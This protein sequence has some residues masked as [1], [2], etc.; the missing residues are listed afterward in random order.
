MDSN[1][2][3]RFKPYK[4]KI[5]SES[6]SQRKL[7]L[8]SISCKIGTLKSFLSVEDFRKNV[9]ALPE[10]FKFNVDSGSRKKVHK[11][12]LSMNDEPSNNLKK[13][14]SSILNGIQEDQAESVDER[15]R[16]LYDKYTINRQK[17]AINI[18]KMIVEEVKQQGG[19]SPR[20]DDSEDTINT[21]EYSD[22]DILLD[23]RKL[24]KK[25]QKYSKLEEKLDKIS[26]ISQNLFKIASPNEKI[27]K[28]KNFKNELLRAELVPGEFE[29]TNSHESN[30]HRISRAKEK[31]V[32]EDSIIQSGDFS[33]LFAETPYI[34]NVYKTTY[35]L[36][37][38]L[39][40][41]LPTIEDPKQSSKILQQKIELS[42][43]F[44]QKTSKLKRSFVTINR[45]C[46][47]L[48]LMKI[49]NMLG[50][51]IIQYFTSYKSL[52]R[53]DLSGNCIGDK[54]VAFLVYCLNKFSPGLEYLDLS[55]TQ[56]SAYTSRAVQAILESSQIQ[57]LKL[58]KNLFG[59]EGVLC[60]SVGLLATNS[61][62]FINLADNQTEIAAGLA[63]AKVFRLNR[64]LKG[65]NISKNLISGKAIKEISR[66]LIVNTSLRSLVMNGCLLDDEDAKEIGHM[67]NA[68]KKL[69]QLGLSYNKITYKGLEYLKYGL[70]KNKSLIHLSLTGNKDI[71]LPALEKIKH[72]MPKYFEIEIGKED[73][74]FKTDEA[75]KLK[76]IDYFR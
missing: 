7:V 17:A 67:L 28:K 68:N 71:K 49:D 44:Q 5:N 38:Q 66:S 46:I 36:V 73:E 64:S 39:I 34:S 12:Y 47:S 61:L 70:P 52:T 1:F 60:I 8:P 57:H 45:S 40:P 19:Y 50:H 56:A 23:V 62:V 25:T 14:Q 24:I 9:Q 6:L 63:I 26:E 4:K 75:K 53:V 20:P 31:T 41:K 54:V 2:T 55:N 69:E 51:Y 32:K 74:F 37:S 11:L 10:D 59:D 43:P 13:E 35:N 21:S 29:E 30:F 65:I 15:K 72:A 58:E 3:H 42:S 76:L 18:C 22:T 48:P 16:L 27:K 33:E